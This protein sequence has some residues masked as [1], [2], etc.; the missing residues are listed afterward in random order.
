MALRYSNRFDSL[1]TDRARVESSLDILRDALRRAEDALLGGPVTLSPRQISFYDELL[2]Y[3]DFRDSRYTADEYVEMF[4]R[5]CPPIE[6]ETRMGRYVNMDRPTG[7]STL[8]TE[9]PAIFQELEPK[10]MAKSQVLLHPNV[11]E[12]L[13]KSPSIIPD[14]EA[15]PEAKV[16]KSLLDSLWSQP[17]GLIQD[18][19]SKTRVNGSGEWIFTCPAFEKWSKATTEFSE[20]VKRGENCLWLQGGLGSGKTFLM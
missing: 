9:I 11:E 16:R 8:T 2:E 17:V 5:L 20:S 19:L 4:R 7:I 18:R 10:K 14:Q 6:R 1:R 15:S 13:L 3:H 12:I